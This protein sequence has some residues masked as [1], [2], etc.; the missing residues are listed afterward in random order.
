MLLGV[1]TLLLLGNVKWGERSD[2]RVS[3]PPNFG[4]VFLAIA[5]RQVTGARSTVLLVLSRCRRQMTT[6]CDKKTIL[7][8]AVG[9]AA[10]RRASDRA[11]AMMSLLLLLLLFGL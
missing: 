2:G 7:G 1:L 6:I 3:T 5:Q 11:D 10:Q 9:C 8:S 4:N